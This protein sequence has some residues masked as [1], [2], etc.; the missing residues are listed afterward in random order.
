[1]MV[2]ARR[3]SLGARM[4]IQ[5]FMDY[6]DAPC[7][8][9]AKK[10]SIANSTAWHARKEARKMAKK[11]PAAKKVSPLRVGPEVKKLFAEYMSQKPVPVEILQEDDM[12]NNPPHYQLM[13]GVEVYDVLQ[14][15]AKKGT[16]LGI[17]NET[18]RNY[19][20]G[21]EYLLRM[22]EKNGYQDLCKALWYLHALRKIMRNKLKAT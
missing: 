11:K 20:R 22:W 5:Y 17:D 21:A 6:P 14:A 3:K 19:D 1:M 18:W 8:I 15:L 10:F 12:V 2:K 13:P 7:S 9:G 16:A 4:A